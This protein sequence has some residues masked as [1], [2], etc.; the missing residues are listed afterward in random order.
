MPTGQKWVTTRSRRALTA[1]QN[2]TSRA[3]ENSPG[4]RLA[5]R[6]TATAVFRTVEIGCLAVDGKGRA[7]LVSSAAQPPCFLSMVLKTAVKPPPRSGQLIGVPVP[8]PSS[9]SAAPRAVR[10]ASAAPP[11]VHRPPAVAPAVAV[12]RPAAAAA[13]P[14]AA[15]AALLAAAS[16]RASRPLIRPWAC[17]C[18]CS[19]RACAS[20][21]SSSARLEVTR[22]SAPT[23]PIEPACG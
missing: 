19:P 1:R 10:P 17:A 15:A 9:P 16:A 8:R 23:R 3:R 6:P 2:E 12:A 20:P 13:W 18:R 21:R 14:A 4:T 7:A 11:D 22:P 5:K